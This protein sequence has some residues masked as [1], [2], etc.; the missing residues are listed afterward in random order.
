V[1]LAVVPLSD[2]KGL[3]KLITVDGVAKGRF[4]CEVIGKVTDSY[5]NLLKGYWTMPLTHETH[6]LYMPDVSLVWDCNRSKDDAKYVRRSC[7]PNAVARAVW[8]EGTL[9]CGLW[10]KNEADIKPGE[11]VTVAWDR[12]WNSLA[13]HIPCAC[14]PE[15][16]CAVRQWYGER[17]QL[18]LMLPV[19]HERV[20]TRRVDPVRPNKFQAQLE[21][22]L[23][24]LEIPEHKMSREE[25]KLAQVL[26]TIEK[27]EQ[28]ER[29]QLKMSGG[30]G[31][32]GG[33]GSSSRRGSFSPRSKKR[34]RSKPTEDTETGNAGEDNNNSNNNNTTNNNTNNDNN[35]SNNNNNNNSSNDAGATNDET[36]LKAAPSRVSPVPAR[37]APGSPRLARVETPTQASKVATPPSKKLGGKKAW[38]HKFS[39]VG[40]E[41]SP[42]TAAPAPAPLPEVVKT[43]GSGEDVFSPNVYGWK[44][45]AM[46]AENFEKQLEE[47]KKK[48]QEEEAQPPAPKKAKEE[49]KVEETKKSGGEE[50][51]KEKE[52]GG[53]YDPL[54]GTI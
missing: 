25:R 43:E 36:A 6:E 38:L 41:S 29:N 52:A 39:E 5:T 14:P 24:P 9:R 51:G 42:V 22:T 2:G 27:M 50:A 30:A 8:A 32:G 37:K 45:R 19:V 31:E 10:A 47:E 16:A 49:E 54:M 28:R 17:E 15:S 34:P 4:I 12:E 23:N 21:T 48:K 46:M 13:C 35:K 33:S 7:Q 40:V 53:G 20:G 18:A 26:K 11:E 44:K 1:P 3:K